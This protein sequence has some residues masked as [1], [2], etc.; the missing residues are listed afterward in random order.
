MKKLAYLLSA[1]LIASIGLV[2]CDTEEEKEGPTI[3]DL[4]VN[5]TPV[6]GDAVTQKAGSVTITFTVSDDNKVANYTVLAGST[7]QKSEKVDAAS[8]EVTLTY[9]LVSSV[10]ITINATDDDDKTT[11]R[12]FNL[13]KDS[14]LS[15]YSTKLLGAQSNDASGSFLA[16][17]T[18]NVYKQAEA[19]TNSSV[20]DILYY[21]G[22]TNEATLAAPNDASAATIYNNAT[23][24]LQ[25][26]TKT[27][28]T[29]F[30]VTTL[31]ETQ[32]TNI[33]DDEA[34]KAAYDAV[35][36]GADSKANLLTVSKIVA[37]K[38]E[39]GKYGL[40]HVATIVTGTSGSITINVK[41][42]K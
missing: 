37:F 28:A 25:T 30:K 8:K 33:A 3:T 31:T 20:V 27:N 34:V 42:G 6:T 10:I 14:N 17:V 5:G 39:A 22:A 29:T 21:F 16:T 26:W 32:F 40:A 7:S 36:T 11:T 2:G 23:T 41:V 19:K 35:T 38:T 18:G 9:T 24:G 1:L 15:S 13:N 12:T 4:K